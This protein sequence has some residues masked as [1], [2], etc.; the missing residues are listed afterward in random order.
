M[1][2]EQVGQNNLRPL[3]P[4][5]V[6]RPGELPNQCRKSRGGLLHLIGSSHMLDAH[7]TSR[8]PHVGGRNRYILVWA[9]GSED[10]RSADD[11]SK[12]SGQT[13]SQVSIA[14]FWTAG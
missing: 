14:P 7:Y 2:E 10:V 4:E 13:K 12:S 8:T 1:L 5:S 3:G 11:V 9:D 6:S